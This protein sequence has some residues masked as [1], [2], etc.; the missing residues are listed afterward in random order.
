MSTVFA[1][2]V[3][4]DD[5]VA[6]R[7]LRGCA[8]DI[9]DVETFLHSRI[10]TGADL[11]VRPLINADATR[12]RIIDGIR[13]HLGQAGPGDWALFWF[14]GHGSTAPLPPEI[15]FMEAGP[16]M[17][18]LVCVDSRTGGVP[19]LFDKELWLLLG[20][21]AS[22]RAQVVAVLDTCHSGG[23]SRDP[24]ILTRAVSAAPR[25]TPVDALIPELIE[26]TMATGEHAVPEFLSLAACR[27][28]E[29]AHEMSLGAAYRGVFTWSML[30]ALRRLGA[31]ASC[32]QLLT[33]ARCEV[34]QQVSNQMPQLD[35]V[36]G[37]PADTVFLGGAISPR[38][39]SM[40]MRFHGG[41]WELNVGACHGF[42]QTA[43][44]GEAHVAVCGAT[45]LHE[46]R[47]AEVLVRSTIVEP[48]GW[49]PEIDRQYPMMLSDIAL[50]ATRVGEAGLANDPATVARLF[51]AI[52]TSGPDRRPSP[53]LRSATHTDRA[54]LLV[55]T[56]AAD[57]IRIL[58]P[59]GRPLFA[60]I[61]DINGN[62]TAT[63]V[64]VLEHIARWRL[65]RSLTNPVSG[66][67]GAVSV[68]LVP[69][70]GNQTP[71]W[72]PA[73]LIPDSGGAIALNYRWFDR[74][75]V[76]PR[77]HIRLHNTT[78]RRLYCALLD[79]T[80]RYAIHAGLFDGADI[81]PYATGSALHGK[82]IEFRMPDGHPVAPGASTTDWLLLVASEQEFS[83]EPFEM[84][85]L[86]VR[87]Q[88]RSIQ[89][90]TT[91]GI[92]DRIAGPGRMRDAVPSTD[93]RAA[94]D[95]ATTLIPVVTR[96]PQHVYQSTT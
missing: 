50:P 5:Y 8:N 93:V 65:V 59:E 95:W 26:R 62:G 44:G 35:P 75:W 38:P 25:A 31:D 91:G 3:G 57:L 67:A 47:I 58:D 77:L 61:P 4:I 54:H 68:E 55:S 79:L 20:D 86:G 32:R 14:S 9:A 40:Q 49:E 21:V 76:P 11:K 43:D 18:T 89:P 63:A 66:L 45:P 41:R 87:A 37:R 69:A 13:H 46:A 74:R 1:L 36:A 53:Y 72:E 96:V 17:Q 81:D 56:P 42:A 73:M 19:D 34:E 80:D 28:Y 90:I 84:T 94:Y 33:A 7:R 6:A 29:R 39:A 16:V 10:A 51:A 22:R 30:R 64:G 60:D 70:E 82:P 27:A 15:W 2:L 23:A 12:D 85:E 88:A 48:L 71:G 92:L 83:V 52:E 78:A 24:S